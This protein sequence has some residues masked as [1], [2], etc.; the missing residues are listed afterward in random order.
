MCSHNPQTGARESRLRLWTCWQHWQIYICEVVVCLKESV[1]IISVQDLAFAEKWRRFPYS[2]PRAVAQSPN[3]ISRLSPQLYLHLSAPFSGTASEDW[4][5]G[6]HCTC[7][8][9]ANG[10]PTGLFFCSTEDTFL[11]KAFPLSLK[12]SSSFMSSTP[13]R[14]VPSVAV[15][16][17]LCERLQ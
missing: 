6:V 7:S 5:V 10:I 16:H 2:F 8:G 3:L 17:R 11:K 12:W 4:T 13:G 9:D 14:G 1:G 15:D